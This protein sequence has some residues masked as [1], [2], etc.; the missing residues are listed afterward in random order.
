MS[1]RI[2]SLVYLAGDLALAFLLVGYSLHAQDKTVPSNVGERIR[3]IQ[4]DESRQQTTILQLQQQYEGTQQALKNDEHEIQMLIKEALDSA[5]LK[6]DEWSV[7]V[8]NCCPMK[9]IAKT[10]T[11]PAVPP[12]P[13]S[14][15]KKK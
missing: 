10:P 11:P 3:N 5:N 7:D 15:D 9:F 14:G 1:R 4:L 13:A 8:T 6:A 2:L 12:T